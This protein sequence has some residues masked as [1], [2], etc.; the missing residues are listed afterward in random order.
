MPL[1][2]VVIPTH[3]RPEMLAEAITSVRAQTFADYEIVVVS[4]GESDD[5]RRA[6]REVT[7]A[8]DGRYFA[9]RHGNV[10]GARNFGV[11]QAKS[12][13][14]AF[15][16][17]DDLWLPNK[18]ER[19]VAEAQRTGADMIA[20]YCAKFFPDGQEIIERPRLYDGW[21]YTKAISRHYWW[22]IPSATIIRKRVLDEVGGFDVHLSYIEDMDLWRRISWRYAIHQMDEVLTQYRCGHLTTMHPQNA[23]KRHLWNLRHF[24]KM[25]RDTPQ[26]LRHMVPSAAIFVPPELIG[27][28]G[29]EWLLSYLRQLR[30]RARWIHLRQWLKLRTR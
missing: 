20:C 25:C 22:T 16:D 23:R 19:Q 3:N 2:S 21:S 17:D 12:E 30:P 29:P 8:H 6:S 11:E 27:I 1:V 7:T 4:N 9:L 18:L 13:W 26:D 14:I 5:M 28:L 15:L 10:S 24:A